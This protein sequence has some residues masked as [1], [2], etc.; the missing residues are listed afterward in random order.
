MLL[1]RALALLVGLVA[2]LAPRGARAEG[3]PK[4]QVLAEGG[5]PELSPNLSAALVG[6]TVTSIR[7]TVTSER[8]PDAP[9]LTGVRVGA[10]LA[11]DAGR[12]LLR[13]ALGSGAFASGTVTAEPDGS[14]VRLVVRLV[15]RRIVEKVKLTGEILDRR[16]TLDAAGLAE[17]EEVTGAALDRV[18]GRIREEYARRGYPDA[19]VKLDLSATDRP[20]HVVLFIEVKSGSERKIAKRVF[21]MS[22]EERE[23]VGAL[24]DKYQVGG[25]AR[26][27]EVAIQQ[28]DRELQDLLR[29]ERFPKAR[30]LHRLVDRALDVKRVE[31]IL[32]VYVQAGPRLELSFEGNSAYDA[33]QL[34][35][36]LVSTAA[37]GEWS[38]PDVADRL[39]VYYVQ[40]GFHDVEL[41]VKEAAGSREGARLL[42]V[43]VHEGDRVRV[44]HRVFPCLAGEFTADQLGRE[45]DGV[46]A[47]EL[48]A[49]DT[50]S[51][52]SVEAIDAA[53]GGSTGGR[54]APLP[55]YA[56]AMV[57]SA[58]AYDRALKHVRDLLV[59]RGYL[60]A[61]VGPM[62]VVRP[63]CDPK[64]PD[65]ACAP[66]P[67]P[68]LAQAVCKTDS[69][70]LPLPEP[71]APESL[72]CKPDPRKGIRCAAEV[73]LRIPIHLGPKTT[74][75]DVAFEGNTAFTAK[76]LA[77]IAALKPGEALSALEV[78]AARSRILDA[79]RKKGFAFAELR[80][81]IEPSPDRTRARARFTVLERY[82]VIV[83]DFLV[84][85]NTRT[86]ESLIRSR[87]SLEKEK[88]FRADLARQSEER[89]AT[90]GAFSSVSVAL[91][92]P[93]IPNPRKRV[94]VTV[95]EQLPQYMNP[96]VGFSTGDGL[97]FAFEY[98]HR[99]IGGRAIALTLRL[100]LNYLFDFLIIDETMRRNYLG[101][102]KVRADGSKVQIPALSVLDRLERRNTISLIVPDIG[103]GP[104]VS[105]T[106][107]GI[108]IRDNQRDFG[109]GREALIPT[110]TYRPIREVT[111]QVSATFEFNDVNVFDTD[112]L[113]AGAL[114]GVLRVPQG[115]T[116][117]FSQ[118][119]KGTLDLRDNA[120]NAT[121]G[122][123]AT[124]SV[125][126]VNALP[127][128]LGDSVTT[129]VYSHFLRLSG[130]VAGYVP[131]GPGFS[132]AL[133]LA[134]GV[135]VQLED[136][137]ETYP[138]RLFF[139]GGFDTIRAF[140]LDSVVPQDIAEKVVVDS[141]D[142]NAFTI[143][144]VALRGGNVSLSPRVELRIP[145]YS[146]FQV[147]VFFDV[148]N[149]WF[150]IRQIDLLKWRYALGGGIRIATPAGPL[151]FDYGFNL[152]KRPWEDIGAFHFSVGLF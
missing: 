113:D 123:F 103:L 96:T 30:V 74:L 138:D 78:D 77:E 115:R 57:L 106:L 38:A 39:R 101:G 116:V 109:L 28:A 24:R 97:R 41:Q 145:V 11:S 95:V 4:E 146:V 89:I 128:N 88:P 127:A 53:F 75:W 61:V 119:L 105:L 91:E 139:L 20:N 67:P 84:R 98:G 118:R 56:P 93:Q 94:I 107:D 79:Y 141:T 82:A 3:E 68:E 54:R 132:L 14:G 7:V 121:K 2:L 100:Q 46:L 111:A 63:R 150:D 90:L 6:L 112:A 33:D 8:F 70:R 37:R 34:E 44:L 12:V 35:Q 125:E 18:Q 51:I 25:G 22:D 104:L 55:K 110:L 92:D 48:P 32:Y 134:G 122:F 86:E 130:R 21:V 136:T 40:R 43:T 102:E 129:D 5:T 42:R 60:N 73:S 142:P 10:P 16:A 31:T 9:K 137:S 36:H 13:E 66:L 147:G 64:S 131:F 135:N 69:L 45:M 47:E 149:S 49:G 76:E 87:L 52:A 133:S 124:A 120:L 83:D 81:A 29:A 151:A 72:T 71:P 17:G 108:D 152:D 50:L 143:D 126:H 19:S 62:T 1:L 117:A 23:V 80:S 26:A 27:D 144:K 59:S 148:A 65:G 140:L 58:E 114:L 15:P 85:G 99:N